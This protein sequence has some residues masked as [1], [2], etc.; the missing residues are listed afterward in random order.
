MVRSGNVTQ[1]KDFLMTTDELSYG[2]VRTVEPTKNINQLM[3]EL[4]LHDTSEQSIWT[5]RHGNFTL[6]I[7]ATMGETEKHQDEWHLTINE[8]GT[9][10]LSLSSPSLGSL[11]MQYS[12]AVFA[13]GA[14]VFGG[15]K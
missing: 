1:R 8:W 12:A 7:Q 10:V 4:G 5:R 6:T 9:E 11:I 13:I 3:R 14:G 2:L 15:G